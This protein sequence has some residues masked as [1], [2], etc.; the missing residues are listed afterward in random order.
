MTAWTAAVKIVLHGYDTPD[1]VVGVMHPCFIVPPSDFQVRLV[2]W[3]AY[4]DGWG[5]HGARGWR[6][7]PACRLAH[8]GHTER[9]REG[10]GSGP[11]AYGLARHRRSV[12]ER[13]GGYGGESSRGTLARRLFRFVHRYFFFAMVGGAVGKETRAALTMGLLRPPLELLLESTPHVRV[14]FPLASA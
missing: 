9:S 4:D 14:C 12:D 6:S 2:Q 5:T 10:P 7:G 1:A 3:R 13:Y 8:A 11:G